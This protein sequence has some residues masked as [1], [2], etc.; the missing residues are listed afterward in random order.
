MTKF[1][2]TLKAL[3]TVSA[4][5]IF[6]ATGQGLAEAQQAFTW[7]HVEETAQTDHALSEAKIQIK[8]DG[9]NAVSQLNVNANNGSVVVS[10]Q[11]EVKFQTFWNYGAFIERAEVR[12]FSADQS[13][14]DDQVLIF[15]VADGVA[16]MPANSAFAEDLIYVLRV[17]G[18]E[19]RF[20][21]T[22]AKPLSVVEASPARGFLGV[23]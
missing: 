4:I 9:I 6:T 7:G 1:N 21:E 22:V 13:V 10:K 23:Q 12:V 18:K 2:H 11:D 5:A 19:G 8:Y 20:D 3:T 16:T 14:R 15:P 17:Y